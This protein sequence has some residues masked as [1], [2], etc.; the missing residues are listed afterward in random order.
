[1]PNR[2]LQIFVSSTYGD[3]IAERL[4]A[5]E[6]ILAAGHIPAAMEQFTPGDETAWEK[7]K[8]WIDESDAFMLILAG[9][10]GSV[11]P[12]SGKSYVQLEYE[13]A[14]EKKKPFFALVVSAAAREVR[15]KTHG[16]A[17]LE[18]ANH[19]AQ[20]SFEQQVLADH[21]GFWSDTKDIQASVFRKLPEW[22]QRDHLVGWVRG[23]QAAGSA[24]LH[25]LA[26]LSRESSELRDRLAETETS[27]DGL[28]LASLIDELH[29]ALPAVT[30]SRDECQQLGLPLFIDKCGWTT[31]LL[32]SAHLGAGADIV[33]H[34]SVGR[35]L[36]V[37]ATFGLIDVEPSTSDEYKRVYRIS[38]QGRQLRGTLME[39]R[40]R[41]RGDS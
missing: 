19:A 7:I 35:V 18:D 36:N 40:R 11:E 12:T 2:K 38:R 25:E 4:S 15:I 26:R 39:E 14:R 32:E 29:V 37:M 22:A 8:R 23:D 13:Y 9:R 16:P 3:L 28:S 41:R 1:M 27:F 5:I 30:V 24:T 21:C 31:L 20:K 10:Y 33:R 6:A 17:V 34:E